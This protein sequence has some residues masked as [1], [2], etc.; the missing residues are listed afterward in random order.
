MVLLT[1]SQEEVAWC[2]RLPDV[3]ERDITGKNATPNQK[4]INSSPRSTPSWCARWPPPHGQKIWR[5]GD[6]NPGPTANHTK[7]CKAGV[8]PLHHFP[9]VRVVVE[10][11]YYTLYASRWT[12]APALPTERAHAPGPTERPRRPGLASAA[13]LPT[14]ACALRRAG[15]AKTFSNSLSQTLLEQKD[16]SPGS[17]NEFEMCLTPASLGR[18]VGWTDTVSRVH[19]MEGLG[20]PAHDCNALTQ[21]SDSLPAISRDTIAVV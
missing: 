2:A 9:G 15:S 21:L 17:E 14:A 7:P 11:A 20:K 12:C 10:L 18:V 4:R 5:N 6:L 8:L 16:L 3:L 13:T 1:P 19:E